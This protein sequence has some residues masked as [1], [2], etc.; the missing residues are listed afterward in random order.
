MLAATPYLACPPAIQ[1]AVADALFAEWP[2]DFALQNV[3]TTAQCRDALLKNYGLWKKDHTVLFVLT[4]AAIRTAPFVGTVSLEYSLTSSYSPCIANVFVHPT[5]RRY[6][7]GRVLMSFAE[8]Y[9]KKQKM[10]AAYLWCDPD[11]VGFYEKRGYTVVDAP[12][13]TVK[14]VRFMGKSL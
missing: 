10:T 3:T 4:D 6:G 12:T 13:G 1:S 8:K 5:L 7:F 2:Q 14:D 11:L 9:L